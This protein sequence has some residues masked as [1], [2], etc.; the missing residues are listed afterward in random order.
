MI[1]IILITSIVLQFLAAFIAFQIIRKIAGL[2]YFWFFTTGA[3]FLMCVRRIIPLYDVL[4]QNSTIN[5]YN[6]II[7][8]FLS[9]LIFIVEF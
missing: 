5:I 1:I 7:G 3:L 6:E 8:L 2:K 9:L 4:I